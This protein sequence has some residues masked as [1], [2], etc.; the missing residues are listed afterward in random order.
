MDGWMD[1]QGEFTKAG[2]DS[3]HTYGGMNSPDVIGDSTGR[4]EEKAALCGPVGTLKE[5]C[6]SAEGHPTPGNRKVIYLAN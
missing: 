1:S 2:K 3:G 5:L 4:G 6:T